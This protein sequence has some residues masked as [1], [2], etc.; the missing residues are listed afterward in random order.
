MTTERQAISVER[1]SLALAAALVLA[2]AACGGVRRR[3]RR[4]TSAQP[5]ERRAAAS[6]S[7]RW[8]PRARSSASSPRTSGGEPGRQ[9]QR[10]ADRRDVAHDKILTSVAGN[11]TP[12]REP[13]RH[14]LDGRVRARPA[15]S[16]RCPTSIDTDA[17]LRGRARHRRS[18]TARPT[19]CRGTSRRGVL[20]YRTDIAEKAG[21]TE[22]PKTWDELKAMA[23]RDEGE[24]RRQVRHQPLAEQL[25][26]VPAVRLAERRRASPRATSSRSTRPRPSRRSTFYKSFFD[27]GLTA[28]QRPSRASTS[29][30]RSCAARTRCSSPARGTWA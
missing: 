22:A 27:E 24:G 13:D 26:G 5:E 10:H 30:P 19:A 29:R 6:R 25:A 23:Q 18:S 1:V 16:R 4:A 28:D 14:D 2:V 11:K 15:R 12:G 20:Y 17:V 8:A 7:G 21:I 3:R 9:G